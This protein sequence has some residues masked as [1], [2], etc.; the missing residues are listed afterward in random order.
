MFNQ[1][2]NSV[3]FFLWLV[4]VIVMTLAINNQSRIREIEKNKA[5][6]CSVLEVGDGS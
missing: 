6:E 2:E 5:E 4:I 3:Y 1:W